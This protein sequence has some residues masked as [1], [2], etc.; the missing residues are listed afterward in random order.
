MGKTITTR[1]FLFLLT[2]N[3][4]SCQ[5]KEEQLI[6]HW[7]EYEV[8][9]TDYINCHKITDST[10]SI[11]LETYGAGYPIKRG[12]EIQKDEIAI[13]DYIFITDFSINN[14]KLIVN[15][16]VYWIKQEDNEQTFI[17][18]FSAGLLVNIHPFET[19]TSEFDYDYKDY[20]HG[21][22]IHIYIGKLKKNT[23]NS[24]KENNI[25]DYYI[26]LNERISNLKD[27]RSFL[28]YGSHYDK[29]LKVL[30]HT[31]KNTP[32]DLLKQIELEIKNCGYKKSQ[33]YYQTVNTQKRV[34]GFNRICL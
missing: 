4:F 2:I 7:H 12:V 1:S 33:I 19:T 3:L 30:L 16:S 27:I 34:S 26:Q 17:S 15:D 28:D 31:D 14:N 24:H 25:R 23:Q 21:Y 22:E 6:G 18:D 20:N 13:R 8:G 32:K 29:K 9:N 11:D 5:S 10:Y